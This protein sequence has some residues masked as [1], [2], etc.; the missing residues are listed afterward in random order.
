MGRRRSNPDRRR[1]LEAV[2]ELASQRDEDARVGRP[3][4]LGRGLH[5]GAWTIPV[6]LG[7]GEW[8]DWV[9]QVPNSPS[10]GDDRRFRKEMALLRGLEK[11]SRPFDIPDPVG[12]VQVDD[13]ITVTVTHLCRGAPVDSG[14]LDPLSAASLLGTV[15]AQVHALPTDDLVFPNTAHTT[16]RADALQGLAELIEVRDL[17]PPFIDDVLGWCRRHLPPEDQ[18]SVL[19]HGDL[20]AQNVLHR[21]DGPPAVVDWELAG[22]GDPAVDLAIITRGKRRP[23]GGSGTRER[24]IEAYNAIAVRPV[25]LEAVYV[26]ELCMVADEVAWAIEADHAEQARQYLQQLRKLWNKGRHAERHG[27]GKRRR[28]ARGT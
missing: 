24:L 8:V 27:K 14:F 1:A 23:L 26:H 19:T 7:D 6:D 11:L 10:A 21:L 2:R 18:A 13:E 12:R 25:T 9:A 3:R 17:D 22:M 5:R 16:A 4:F 15:A 20:L 28:R